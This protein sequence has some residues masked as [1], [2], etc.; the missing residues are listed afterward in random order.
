M[1]LY[2]HTACFSSV[3]PSE[4]GHAVKLSRY[5]V[6]AVSEMLLLDPRFLGDDK[7]LWS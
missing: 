5:P 4:E 3:I 1:V 6:K 2:N 7:I